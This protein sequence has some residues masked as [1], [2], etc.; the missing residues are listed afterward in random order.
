MKFYFFQYFMN[1]GLSRDELLVIFVVA[2]SVFLIST[3]WK[4]RLKEMS[5]HDA[6]ANEKDTKDTR[7]ETVKT[8][9]EKR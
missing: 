5:K 6:V 2:F 4:L 3:Y 1:S 8:G 9:E 7:E